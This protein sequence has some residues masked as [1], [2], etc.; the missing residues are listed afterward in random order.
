M[1]NNKH[2][3]NQFLIIYL[4]WLF[5]SKDVILQYSSNSIKKTIIEINTEYFSE[6]NWTILEW[7]NGRWLIKRED[8]YM[9]YKIVKLQ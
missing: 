7:W 6:N 4:I 9:L 5:L 1:R 2:L 3:K 8:I